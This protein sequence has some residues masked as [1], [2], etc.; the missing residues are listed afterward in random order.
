MGGRMS[1]ESPREEKIEDSARRA[2]AEL[3]T[4][5]EAAGDTVAPTVERQTS[6]QQLMACWPFGQ[7]ESRDTSEGEITVLGQSADI[8]GEVAANAASEP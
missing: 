1:G 2:G 6:R 8:R 7:H 4:Q 5:V 3:E